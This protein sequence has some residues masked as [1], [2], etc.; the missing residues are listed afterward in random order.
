[1]A[2]LAQ[3]TGG[4]F[5][6]NDN[7]LKNGFAKLAGSPLQY[8]LTFAP[9]DMKLDGKFHS[10]KVRLADKE[11]KG[12]SVQARR[13]YFAPKNETEA[14]AQAMERDT[15]EADVQMEEQIHEALFAKSVVKELPVRLYAQR[16][17]DLGGTRDISFSTISIPSH[18]I[19][20]KALTATRTP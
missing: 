10:L 14:E 16:K 19:F 20:I 9:K 4:E 5:F 13:G 7:D 2:E 8:V 1:M 18:C 3:G 15:L 11:R 17:R 6:H 12:V